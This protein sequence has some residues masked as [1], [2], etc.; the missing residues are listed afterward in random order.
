MF[1]EKKVLMKKLKKKNKNNIKVIDN[2]NKK[3]K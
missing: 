3:E 1:Y 2:R